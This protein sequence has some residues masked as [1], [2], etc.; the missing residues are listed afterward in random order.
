MPGKCLVIRRAEIHRS[1]AP[2]GHDSS[3]LVAC[4]GVDDPNRFSVPGGLFVVG[5]HGGVLVGKNER[6]WCASARLGDIVQCSHCIVAINR[7]HAS[8][9]TVGDDLSLRIAYAASLDCQPVPSGFGLM[10]TNI[11]VVRV[12]MDL[13]LHCRCGYVRGLASKVSPSTGC[14]FVCYCKD[15]QA[16]ARFLKRA[17]VLDPAGG[18][19]IFQMPPGHVTLTAGTDAVRCLR[20]SDKGVLRW[21]ADCCRT[22]IANSAGPGFPMIGVIHSFVDYEFLDDLVESANRD[23]VLGPRLCRI[24]EGSAVGPLPPNAPPPP[25]PF[26]SVVLQGCSAGGCAGSAGRTRSS[27]IAPRLRCRRRSYLCQT[28]APRFDWRRLTPDDNRRR[29][30]GRGQAIARRR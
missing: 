25:S 1:N 8:L 16:F 20:L 7:I 13:P 14:R 6:N 21:Y 30:R 22:P 11:H 12:A 23:P 29:R 26:S 3:R 10:I 18:T 2:K 4:F 17:D 27:T 19:D 5:D 15:C 24:Y 9:G 28:S